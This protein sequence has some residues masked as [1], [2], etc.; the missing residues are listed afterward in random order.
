MV[1]AVRGMNEVMLAAATRVALG[2]RPGSPAQGPLPTVGAWF[3]ASVDGIG[4]NRR[5]VRLGVLVVAAATAGCASEPHVNLA[6]SVVPAYYMTAGGTTYEIYERHD[7]RRVAITVV[8]PPRSPPYAVA[9][10]V[11]DNIPIDLQKVNG[12]KSPGSAYFF[13]LRQYFT[14]TGR[15]CELRHGRPL[16]AAQ[17]EFEY[18][19]HGPAAA[20]A[21]A[22]PAGPVAPPLPPATHQVW[23]Q[24]EPLF[25]P[26]K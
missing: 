26:P 16:V 1:A 4:L 25:K 10:L 12:A 6:Y 15:A 21:L 20:V 18:R 11:F 22:P 13:P 8:S 23:P 3:S 19:C 14:E 24:R 9:D 17:W 7:I 2:R 5:A